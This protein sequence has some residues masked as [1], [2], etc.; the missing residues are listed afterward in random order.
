MDV[1]LFDPGG[2]Y[3]FDLAKGQVRVAEGQR[4]LVL[5]SQAAAPLISAAVASG[6]LTSMRQFGREL[7][8]QVL[9]S[10]GTPAEGLTAEIVLG[11]ATSVLALCGW[12]RLKLERWGDMLLAVLDGLPSLD[13]D[14]LAAAALLGGLFSSLSKQDVA[15][16]P[17][18]EPGRFA[19]VDPSIAETVWSWS[20]AGDDAAQIASK[21]SSK[22]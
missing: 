10:L 8:A 7:A 14:N 9:E 5:S 6:D 12:G 2:F 17:L 15:C 19:V 16:V 21:V 18:S 11:H 22:L 20:R 4:M 1:P 3:E 13:R